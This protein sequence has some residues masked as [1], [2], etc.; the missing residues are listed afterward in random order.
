MP[1][2]LFKANDDV[3]SHCR[4]ENEPAAS[5]TQLDCPWCGCGWLISCSKCLKAFT[6][7]VIRDVDEPII[8]IGKREALKRGYD[9]ITEAEHVAWAEAMENEFA[10]YN[11]G[12][13]VVYIDGSYFPVDASNVAFDGY[14][15]R[16]SFVTLPHWDALTNPAALRSVLGE[17]SYWLSRE[18]QDRQ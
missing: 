10:S 12:Q 17:E 2:F 1:K 13:T 7:G 15:A 14:F 4:C 6:Y 3:I 11:I 16:H 5:T 9:D 18:L 8:E